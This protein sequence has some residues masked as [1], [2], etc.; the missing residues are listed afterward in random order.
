MSPPN[1]SPPPSRPLK[2]SGISVESSLDC[3]KSK[4]ISSGSTLS[5][6]KTLAKVL[7]A[8]RNC[9]LSSA[10]SKFVSDKGKVPKK[11]NLE[12][13]WFVH[14]KFCVWSLL[15]MKLQKYEN[16]MYLSLFTFYK[17]RL[18]RW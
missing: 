14:P 5:F 15:A 13:Q 4:L 9:A 1:P 3:S 12:Y 16:I 8:G 18:V 7:V 10:V 11:F 17:A 6:P 2:L